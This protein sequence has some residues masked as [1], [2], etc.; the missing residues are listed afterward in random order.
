[1]IFVSIPVHNEARTIGVLLWKV[2]KIMAEFGRDY[3][4]LVL[5]DA[6]T[7]ETPQVLARYATSLPLRVVRTESR[8][9]YGAALE[10]LL[11][12]AVERSNYPKRDV[13]VTLQGDFTENPEDLVAMVK[14][15]EGGA[16]VVAG[17][18]LGSGEPQ[19]RPIRVSKRIAPLLLGRAF[20]RAPVGD[21]L[22]G[23]RAYRVVV[24]KKAIREAEGTGALVTTSGWGANL[25]LLARVAPHARRIEEAPVGVTYARRERESR[26]RA[27]PN[28]RALL[29]LR[30]TSWPDPPEASA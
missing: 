30:R 8:V 16:D 15:I 13:L 23:Y 10:R 2:R 24:V 12:E 17:A 25:E 28:L 1:L 26:F 9:G 14:A 19:P 4:I 20:S 21:P 3:E 29:A 7:D 11:R 5:D 18:L 22:S 6:S 27:F